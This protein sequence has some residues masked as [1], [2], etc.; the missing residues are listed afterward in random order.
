LDKNS[1]FAKFATVQNEGNRHN[2]HRAD[3]AKFLKNGGSTLFPEE[4]NLLGNINKSTL[5]HLMCNSG[6]DSLSLAARRA[7]VTGVDISD[8][9]I[10][11]A[12]QLSIDSG[13]Y[14]DFYCSDLYN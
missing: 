5:L 14:A 9:P 10:N 3:Q 12:K 1:T 7:N 13:L 4:I 6:Q 2:S 8:E 11:F